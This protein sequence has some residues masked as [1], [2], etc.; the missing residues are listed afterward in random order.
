M[1]FIQ[2]N[3]K[4][5]LYINKSSFLFFLCNKPIKQYTRHADVT[6]KNTRMQFFYNENDYLNVIFI[7]AQLYLKLHTNYIIFAW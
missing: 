5:A 7:F 6:L 2:F 3:T 1:L 4:G